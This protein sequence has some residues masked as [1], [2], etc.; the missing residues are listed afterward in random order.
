MKPLPTRAELEALLTYDP[1]TGHFHWKPRPERGRTWNLRYA[2]KRAA[3]RIGNGYLVVRIGETPYYLHRL[4]FVMMGQP[5]PQ[6]VDHLNADPTDN[7]W[8]NLRS[9]SQAENS[10]NLSLRARNKSGCPG[11]YRKPTG[12]FQAEIRVDNRKIHLGVF[13]TYEEAQ[14]TRLEAERRYGFLRASEHRA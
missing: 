7:R 12:R 4:A 10:R 13:D 6:T 11:V 14:R 3:G 2:G 9:C 1:E 8:C 5:E